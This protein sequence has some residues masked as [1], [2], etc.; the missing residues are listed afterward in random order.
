[1]QP[2]QI[3]ATLVQP[4]AVIVPSVSLAAQIVEWTPATLEEMLSRFPLAQRSW[5]ATLKD[6]LLASVEL[7]QFGE[8]WEHGRHAAKRDAV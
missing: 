6:H 8:D 1:M 7:P 4:A 5:S 3:E 2:A